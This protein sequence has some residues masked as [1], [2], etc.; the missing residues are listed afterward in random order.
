MPL[1][2]VLTESAPAKINLALHVTGRRADGYHLLDSIVA[3]AKLG[4]V[5]HLTRAAETT[6]EITGPFAHRLQ[7]GDEENLV[8]K[9]VAGLKNL[10]PALPHVNIRLE[11]HLPVSSGIGG[12]SADAAAALR[13]L[14]RLSGLS[15]HPQALMELALS[16]GADVPV[17]L[18][19]Q[20]SRMCGIG[21]DVTPLH[22]PA[23]PALI[24]NPGEPCNTQDVFRRL[25]LKDGLP[26]IADTTNLAACRN[27][28]QA[29]AMEGLPVIRQV[30][31]RLE[32]LEGAWLSRMSGSGATC[33]ALFADQAQAQRAAE[34]LRA[35]KPHWWIEETRIG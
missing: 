30:L 34:T 13:G 31:E 23:M 24:V 14:M 25:A 33:F 11:K 5:L 17:C 12:G 3:F 20:A 22:V 4:D 9:A 16:L 28:L 29:P 8:L 6:L 18:K 35:A 10:L 19:S 27:D 32:A 1:A 21:E 15:P 7:A 2:A 26:P